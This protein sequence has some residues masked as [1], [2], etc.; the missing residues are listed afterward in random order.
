MPPCA[1]FVLESS[2]RFF[3]RTSTLARSASSCAS[4]SPPM[5]LPRMRTSLGFIVGLEDGALD[6]VAVAEPVP[7]RLEH[8]DARA[9]RV[10]GPAD[11]VFFRQEQRARMGG[12][13]L[14]A[15][16]GERPPVMVPV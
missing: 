6:L 4:M 16:L 14:A 12:G 1:Q 5:P 13:V 8:G 15:R 10:G 9:R 3:V 7:A 2:A 11:G